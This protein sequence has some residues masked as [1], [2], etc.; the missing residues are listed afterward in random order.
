[1]TVSKGQKWYRPREVARLGLIKNSTGG[2]NE[3][4]NYYFILGLIKSGKLRAKN[5]AKG[6]AGKAYWLIPESEIERYHDT[7]TKL[8][9]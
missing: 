4:S 1:M 2:D 8:E 5:Y 6:P 9:D 7:V 3:L